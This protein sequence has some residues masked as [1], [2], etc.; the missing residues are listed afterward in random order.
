VPI[1]TGTI[2]PLSVISYIAPSGSVTIVPNPVP[3]VLREQELAR[4]T[5]AAARAAVDRRGRR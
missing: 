5:T 2:P 4:A 3:W 1:V